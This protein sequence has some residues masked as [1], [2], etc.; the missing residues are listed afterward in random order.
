MRLIGAYEAVIKS[1]LGGRKYSGSPKDVA[2]A[3]AGDVS[4]LRGYTETVISGASDLSTG[5]L[6][7]EDRAVLAQHARD[8]LLDLERVFRIAFENAPEPAVMIWSMLRLPMYESRSEF[9]EIRWRP[10]TRKEAAQELRTTWGLRYPF[11]KVGLIAGEMDLRL[12]ATL[13]ARGLL[14][15]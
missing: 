11:H 14:N 2:Y 10:Y 15:E 12:H 8:H 13:R 9:G 1:V 7:V 3:V 4:V 6:Q 5:L